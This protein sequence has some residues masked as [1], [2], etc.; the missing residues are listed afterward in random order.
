MAKR[1]HTIFSRLLFYFILVMAIP[2]AI[3][4]IAYFSY[5]D[6]HITKLIKVQT[7]LAIENDAENISAIFDEYK[8]KAFS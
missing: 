3:M 1:T 5:S 7:E 8:H 4:I 6:R 2:L